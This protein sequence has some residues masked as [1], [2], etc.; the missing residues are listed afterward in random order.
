M[1][2][3]PILANVEHLCTKFL[4]AAY[5][6]LL[7]GGLLHFSID[8]LAQYLRG[9]RAPGPESTLFFGLNTAYALGQAL[10]G[11]LALLVVHSGSPM[12]ELWPGLAFGFVAALGWFAVCLL[13]LEYKQPRGVVIVFAVLLGVVALTP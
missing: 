8:V 9:K 5:G 6:W 3:A 11:L 12:L 7:L 13:F 1:R 4:Y 10:V 2:F